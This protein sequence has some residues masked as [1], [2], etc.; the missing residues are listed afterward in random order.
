MTSYPV[1]SFAYGEISPKYFG[2][3]D[4]SYYSQGCKTLKNFYA[5]PIGPAEKRQGT[6]YS[7]SGYNPGEKVILIPWIISPTEGRVLEFGNGY[8]HF[9]SGVTGERIDSEPGVPVYV[10]TDYE[11]DDLPYIRVAQVSDYMYITCYGYAVAKLTRTSDTDWDIDDVTFTVSTGGTQDF[12]SDY[13][14]LC[15]IYEDRLILACT[16]LHPGTIYGSQVG[17]YENFTQ[18]TTASDAWEK[19]PYAKDN[20][21]LLWLLAEKSFLYGTSGGPFRVGGPE[22]ILSPDTAWWPNRQASNGSSSVPAIMVDDFVAFVGKSGRRIYKFAYT[23]VQD[24]YVPDDITTLAEHLSKN[25]IGIVHQ[26]EP[27]SIL[28][29]WTS[30]GVLLSGSY[31][32]ST[33]TIGWTSHDLSGKVESVT[34]IPTTTEDQVWVSVAREIDTDTVRH[35]EY[36]AQ[37]EWDEVEDYHGVDAAVVWDGGAKVVVTS[38]SNNNPAMCTASGHGFSEDD[39]VR[40]ADV[41]EITDVNDEVF[42]IKAVSTDTFELYT[43]DGSAAIDYSEKPSEGIGGTV[44]QVTNKVTGLD[45]LEKETVK[46]W[47]DGA[48]IA[49]ET[50]T[51]G[52]ITLDDYANKIRC[53]L[54]FT[55]SLEPMPIS[56]MRNKLKRIN[57]IWVQFYKTVDAQFGLNG[58]AMKSFAEGLPYVEGGEE[59]IST[60][61]IFDGIA[62]YD[63]VARIESV[64]PGPCTVSAITYEISGEK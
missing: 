43:R 41:E 1:R 29:A 40:F 3:I 38:I 4:T 2:R 36:F 6:I 51:D 46:T 28:W 59:S 52:E 61:E 22:S 37:R 11:E 25:I 56:T 24:K 53:G 42:T 35:I 63:I 30:D 32:S 33:G 15:E 60:K 10:E 50:V 58:E 39:L 57:K 8:I 17:L 19:T 26:R 45:H 31:S 49:D 55:A 54:G 48:I 34:V 21:Q 62:G 12:S 18:G 9:Y 44:E 5:L 23:D 20:N 7:N 14:S 13:P 16:P 47:G 27:G 64:N